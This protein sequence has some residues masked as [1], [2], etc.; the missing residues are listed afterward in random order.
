MIFLNLLVFAAA[1]ANGYDPIFPNSVPVFYAGLNGS[2]CFRI[3]T[4]LRL[5]SKVL[6]AFA[7]NRVTDCGDNGKRHDLVLRRSTDNGATW[8]AL[9]LVAPGIVPCPG[10]PAAISNPNPVEIVRKDGTR[11]VLLHYDTMNNP[12]AQHHG[13]DMQRFSYDE[14]LTW[15]EG[16]VVSYPPMLNS[17]SSSGPLSEFSLFFLQTLAAGVAQFT[18]APCLKTRTGCTG[19][20]IAGQRGR[21]RKEYVGSGNVAL[22]WYTHRY[23]TVTSS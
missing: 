6:L 23:R 7:E 22:R 10:C 21:R 4:V 14:G 17:G 2:K 20:R 3:P 13:L 15:T 18:S 19:A 9:I 1:T 5:H 8:G 16:S 11:V 12:N